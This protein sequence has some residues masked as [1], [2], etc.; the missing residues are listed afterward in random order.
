MNY[1]WGQRAH[2][3]LLMEDEGDEPSP[4]DLPNTSALDYLRERLQHALTNPMRIQKA[5]AELAEL[6]VSL[7]RNRIEAGEWPLFP[8]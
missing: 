4:V 3:V 6:H 1:A 7:N 5:D 8:E 2:F